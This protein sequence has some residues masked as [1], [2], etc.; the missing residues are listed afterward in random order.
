ML[1]DNKLTDRSSWDD[2]KVA[3]V[4]KELSDIALDFEIDATGFEPPEIDLPISKSLPGRVQGIP[5]TN[6]RSPRARPYRNPVTFGTLGKH[7]LLLWGCPGLSRHGADHVP[8]RI[9]SGK[10]RSQHLVERRHVRRTA[11]QSLDAPCPTPRDLLRRILD[12]VAAAESRNAAL[13]CSGRSHTRRYS[14]RSRVLPEPE[15]PKTAT[16]STIL[17]RERNPVEDL[18][19]LEFACSPPESSSLPMAHPFNAPS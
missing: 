13:V 3:I 12:D 1:A 11:P 6:L 7:R 5:R 2:R 15:G 10:A 14:R 19:R 4:L 17:D 16:I 8:G 18:A 9:A